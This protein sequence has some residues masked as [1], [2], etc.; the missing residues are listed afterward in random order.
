M[1]LLVVFLEVVVLPQV[2]LIDIGDDIGGIREGYFED[3]ERI[4]GGYWGNIGG[5][6]RDIWEYIG[7]WEGHC[8]KF[9]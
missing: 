3:I 8:L 6:L 9:I 2:T 5:I 1:I 4:F 7:G